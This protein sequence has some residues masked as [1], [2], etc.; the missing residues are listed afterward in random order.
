[1]SVGFEK[2]NKTSMLY[3]DMSILPVSTSPLKH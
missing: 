1:M 3:V 2:L